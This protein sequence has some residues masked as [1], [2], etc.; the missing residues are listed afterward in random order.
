MCVRDT[1][2]LQQYLA[3]GDRDGDYLYFPESAQGF[4]A[5]KDTLCEEYA[6]PVVDQPETASQDASP[7]IG[8]PG[9]DAET[10]A[11]YEDEQDGFEP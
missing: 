7:E 3:M 2:K 4:E 1:P 11:E 8:H 9:E 10:D 6:P 5:V